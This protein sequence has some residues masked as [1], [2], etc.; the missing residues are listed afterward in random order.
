M[1]PELV[2]AAR[3]AAG[4]VAAALELARACG[5]AVP[6]PGSGRTAERWTLLRRV[7]EADL[8]VARVLEPHVDALAIL[9]E[10]EVPAPPGT[11]GV[12]AAEAAG[13]RLEATQEA[14]GWTLSGVKPWCSLAAEVDRAL[15]TAHAPDGRRLFAVDRRAPGVDVLPSGWLALG[16][17][18]VDSGPVRFERT[19]AT[20]IGA[21]EWYLTR[22]GFSWGGIGVAACWLG[23]ADALRAALLAASPEDPLRRANLGA[24]DVAVWSADRVLAD[25]AR[26]IDAGTADAVLATRVRAVVAGAVEQV[27]TQVGHALG[28]RPLA[29]DAAFAQRVADLQLYVRQHHAERDLAAL[30]GLLL[31]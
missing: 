12:W 10:A 2:P 17:P 7:A 31:R 3:A 27:L 9:A 6:L 4:D 24:A 18:A 14:S 16:L 19:P 30:G 28:P 29:F 15:I 8:T 1:L 25:S 22:P 20:P 13:M 26:E 21:P 23:G 11:F 5:P